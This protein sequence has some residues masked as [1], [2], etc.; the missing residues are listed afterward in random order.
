M[1]GFS[2]KLIVFM[3]VLGIAGVSYA[4]PKIVGQ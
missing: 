1:K 4:A 3:L 2:V